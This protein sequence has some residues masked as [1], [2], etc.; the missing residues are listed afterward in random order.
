MVEQ[1]SNIKQRTTSG[2][3]A[4]T[5]LQQQ[6][7]QLQERI[8]RRGS[9]D[10]GSVRAVSEVEAKVGAVSQQVADIAARLLEVEGDHEFA[11]ENE[12]IPGV[13]VSAVSICASEV[14]SNAPGRPPL[15]RGDV[16]RDGEAGARPQGLQ[17]QLEAVAIHL[18]AMDELTERVAELEQRCNAGSIVGGDGNPEDQVSFG[19]PMERATSSDALTK[20]VDNMNR[21]VAEIRGRLMAAE[22][23]LEKLP[24]RRRTI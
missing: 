23:S 19:P 20:E 1:V 21:E 24:R 10:S 4:N 9:D 8:E 5:A 16:A 22:R 7:Q 17:Q 18:E 6:V 13:E 3:S 11:R 2:E 15:P 14:A 12:I